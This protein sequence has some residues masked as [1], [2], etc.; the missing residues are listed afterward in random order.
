LCKYTEALD[1]CERGI[2]VSRLS[3]LD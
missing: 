2:K 3:S 1:W